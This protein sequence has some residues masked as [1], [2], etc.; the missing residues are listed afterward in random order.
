MDT[1]WILFFIAFIGS[2]SVSFIFKKKRQ[3]S[4]APEVDERVL[5]L[6]QVYILRTLIG[7]GSVGVIL[8]A[9]FDIMGYQSL[10]LSYIWIYL[11]ATMFALSICSF[12][13]KKIGRGE[14]F[15]S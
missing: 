4:Q 3:R 11:L 12:L 2:A 13:A 6:F 5:N 9:T 7:S 10:P 1:A 14:N 8:L 15:P